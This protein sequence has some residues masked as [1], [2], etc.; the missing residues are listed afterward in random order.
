MTYTGTGAS[1]QPLTVGFAPDFTWLKSRSGAYSHGLYDKIRGAQKWLGT[2]S[3]SAEQTYTGTLD[4]FDSNGVTVGNDLWNGAN[5][6]TYVA[7]NWKANGSG[8][9]NT[10]GSITSTVS[11]NTTSGFS[12]VTYTATGSNATVGHGLGAVPSMIIVKSRTLAGGHWTVYH[13]ALGNT[14]GMLMN[15]TDSAYTNSGYWNNTTP[16]STVFSIGTDG[17]VNQNTQNQVAYCFAEVAGYSK[18]GSYTGNG[19]TDGPFVFTGF[20]PA[21]VLTKRTDSTS[22]WQLMDD[23]RDTFNVAN[24]GL[25]PNISVAETTGYNKDFL[26]NG[27][28]IRDSGSSLNASGGTFIYMAFA[29][30]PFKTSLAR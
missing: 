25:F 22:D 18:F 3:S 8:S 10:A 15:T 23:A 26:S 12:V 11:A 16:T 2:N 17:S 19:S 21:F 9:T 28:K 20:R 27:F 5:G 29:E 13:S 24:K 4:S 1:S 6:S 30:S 7:W 14:K